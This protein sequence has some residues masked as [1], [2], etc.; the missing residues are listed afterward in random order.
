MRPP[1]SGSNADQPSPRERA[2]HRS[3]RETRICPD[4]HGN[5]EVEQ[6]TTQDPVTGQWDTAMVLCHCP[7][8]HAMRTTH[9]L[10]GK[11]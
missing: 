11:T 10:G 6:G 9:R 2:E 5:G 3:S 8:G 1:L 7:A 4:C